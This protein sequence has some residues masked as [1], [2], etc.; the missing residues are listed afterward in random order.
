MQKLQCTLVD[1]VYVCSMQ[2]T[3]MLMYFHHRCLCTYALI[4]ENFALLAQVFLYCDH[5]SILQ[6]CHG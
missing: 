4:V 2:S 5:C 1:F 6:G 3:K